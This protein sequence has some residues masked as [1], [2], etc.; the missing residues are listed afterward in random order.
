MPYTTNRGHKIYYTLEGEGPLFIFQH[1]FLDNAE[2]WKESGYVDR[3]KADFKVACIDSLAHGKSDKPEDA[4]SYVLSQRASDIVAVMDDI[5]EKKAHLLGY[6][7]GGWLGVGVAKHFPERLISLMIAG[8][9]CIDGLATVFRPFGIER[10]DFDPFFEQAKEF[11]PELTEWVTE[12]DKVAL[13]LCFNQ[14][15]DLEGSKE[16]VLSLNVPVLLWDGQEDPYHGPMQRFAEE[17]SFAFISTPGDHSSAMRN[18]AD[19]VTREIRNFL[20]YA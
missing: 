9:D 18:N 19:V 4:G 17:N 1:G 6:S 2:C 12:D 20:G 14:L 16:A 3:L 13:E 5:G 7:M 11:M 15:F 10:I 8:W